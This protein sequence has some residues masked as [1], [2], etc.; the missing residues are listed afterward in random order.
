MKTYIIKPQYIHLYG[1]EANQ[2]TVLTDNDIKYFSDDWNRP[3]EELYMQLIEYNATGKAWNVLCRL[4]GQYMDYETLNAAIE[5][6]TGCPYLESEE[7]YKQAIK[8]GF[9]TYDGYYT[10]IWIDG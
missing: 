3:E 6:E 4:E 10:T 8:E 2:Y 5:R 7:D 1:E 9:I